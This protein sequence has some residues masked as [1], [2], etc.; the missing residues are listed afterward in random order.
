[1]TPGLARPA[2]PSALEHGVV[3]QFRG[4]ASTD[5]WSLVRDEQTLPIGT[6][7]PASIRLANA[8]IHTDLP[9]SHPCASTKL[10]RVFRHGAPNR[11]GDMD[12][13]PPDTEL[14]SGPEKLARDISPS[15]DVPKT[16]ANGQALKNAHSN[17][18][19]KSA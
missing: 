11:P 9:V 7:A 1:M 15:K 18:V 12:A 4:E 5:P 19:G 17:E 14:E 16:T 6:S 3:S 10:A 13:R 2:G 8:S